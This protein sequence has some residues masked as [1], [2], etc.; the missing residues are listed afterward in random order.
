MTQLSIGAG[1][2]PYGESHSKQSPLAQL[3]PSCL[4]FAECALALPEEALRPATPVQVPPNDP[5][6]PT[7]KKKRAKRSTK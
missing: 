5:R 7:A 4:S 3:T 6:I 2:K 1:T